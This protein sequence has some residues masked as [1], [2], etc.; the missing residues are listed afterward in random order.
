MTDCGRVEATV[1]LGDLALSGDRA[2]VRFHLP[3]LPIDSQREPLRIHLDFDA[4][5]V[6]ELLEQLTALYAEMEAPPAMN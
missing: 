2:N 3:P 1:Q 4:Y 5:M 6:A